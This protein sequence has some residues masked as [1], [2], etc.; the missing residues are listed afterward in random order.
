MR[1][2][3][4]KEK[5]STENAF[6]FTVDG[7]NLTLGFE[8]AKNF[9]DLLQQA[10][11]E[12]SK[13]AAIYGKN[14]EHMTWFREAN[15]ILATLFTSTSH[16]FG[17]DAEKIGEVYSQAVSMDEDE[18]EDLD[19]ILKTLADNGYRGHVVTRDDME[20]FVRSSNYGKKR[21]TND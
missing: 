13:S 10:S 7:F 18:N 1:S 19:S 8:H 14:S 3:T 6:E 20:K 16:E 9:R 2:L 4:E 17:D 21:Q 12:L 11:G 5:I 15:L